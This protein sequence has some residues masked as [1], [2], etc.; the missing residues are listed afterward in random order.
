M[1]S[2]VDRINEKRMVDFHNQLRSEFKITP[3][4]VDDEFL[5]NLGG[6][7]KS[8]YLNISN[9]N[10]PIT[11]QDIVSDN[12]DKGKQP[13]VFVTSDGQKYQF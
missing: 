1:A 8:K 5:L 10:Q 6:D 4:D 13:T 11:N 7:R 3:E 9:S 12:G 2:V